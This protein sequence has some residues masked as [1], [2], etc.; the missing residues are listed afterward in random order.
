MGCS[1]S[2][3]VVDVPRKLSTSV[4]Q[5]IV[6]VSSAHLTHVTSTVAEMDPFFILRMGRQKFQTSI[7]LK[8]GKDVQ[9]DEKFYFVINSCYQHLGRV[10]EVEAW[11]DDKIGK[12]EIGFGVLDVTHIVDA[13][14]P[15]EH[16]LKCWI[17]FKNQA[18]GYVN[19]IAEFQPFSHQAIHFRF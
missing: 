3:G 12:S 6:I 17:N 18:A 5:L 13:G 14:K 7:K 1:E 15:G 2:N 19:F 9:F 11:D 8:G 16:Q 10:V 4:G